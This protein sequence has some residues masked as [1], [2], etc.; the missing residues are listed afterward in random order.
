MVGSLYSGIS[1]IKTHQ[2]GI[3]VTSN[4][5]ANVN[6]T[7]YR[8]NNAEFKSLFATGLDYINSNSPVSND[9]N[10][11]VT[12][13][14]NAINSNDGTYVKADGQ[15]NVAYSGRGW[16][17]VGTNP[18]GQ[19]DIK[20]PNY[21]VQQNYFTRDG[22]FSLDG[23]G[24]LVNSSGYYMYGIN[25]GKIAPDGTLTGTNNLEEDYANLGGSVLKPIQIPKDLK[26]APTLTTEVNAS[27]NLNR[28][29]NGKGI[30]DVLLKPDG[31]FDMDKFLAQDFNTL[32]D[33]SG[34]PLDAKNYKDI[35]FSI[36]K[37][38]VK[39]D[40]TFT[41][42]G[43]GENGFKSVGE[44][45]DLVKKQ[46][47]LDVNLR[48]DS[49]G[50]PQ[51]C[52]LYV[53]NY[54]MQDIKVD[55]KGKLADKLG[56]SGNGLELDSPMNHL[57]KD[58][59]ANKDY[60]E[61]DY[62]KYKGLIFQK[63]GAGNGGE[64]PIDNEGWTLVDTSRANE[65]DKGKVENYKEDDFV[66]YEGKVY[67]RTNED[68]S[69]I[70]NPDNPDEMIPAPPSEATKGWEEISDEVSGS[71]PEYE[72]GAT[73]DTDDLVS[74][75]GVLYQRVG[76]S[77]TQSPEEDKEGWQV[78]SANA[79]STTQLNVPTYETNIE[80]FSESGEKFILK[81]QYILIEQGDSTA[82]PPI[83]E[84][85]EVRTAI[86]DS[87]GK[88]MVSDEPVI[89][90][91]SFN[92]DG[93]PIGEPFDVPFNGGNIRVDLT[94]SADGK[95]SSNFAYTDSALKSVK[96]DGTEAGI[97]RDITINQ[98][99]IILVNFTNGKTEPIGRFGIAAFVNDQGLSKIGGNLFEMNV[100]TINGQTAVVS[101]P[102][103]MAWEEDGTANLKYGTVLDGMLETS[104][105]DTGTALTDLIV[106]QRGYQMSA[107]SITTADQLMQE[108]IGLKK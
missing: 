93:T 90:E 59:E 60:E 46:T 42:G 100:R 63:N 75:N 30:S 97:M 2:F 5:I 19:F 66:V 86:Y 54:G 39:K 56:L 104:N 29:Q 79:L 85:W 55:I 41:Y 91:L 49:E 84:R 62:I 73:Y 96:Q 105:V 33:A 8:A 77:S 57:I 69:M 32:M 43:T 37:N 13:G 27:V 22:S 26:Y 21:Q 34:K 92:P 83:N 108:A 61:G 40:Y 94:Q 10:F 25:L 106:Y 16:F 52:S 18:N 99:G 82:N 95:K 15:F 70:P 87:Q 28:S 98:D 7:G 76:S 65:Y 23:D 35:T 74:Y 36:E 102:P 51:D 64:S 11:G 103:L 4:N 107:K 101:G 47:G 72:A 58:F 12:V 80:V 1:G 9:Y 89:N 3:D 24:Y 53:S 20:N 38:G 17:V 6:T 71:I 88:V 81:S 44:F 68:I 78:V 14:S 50:N 67:R 45:I 31:T 48:L